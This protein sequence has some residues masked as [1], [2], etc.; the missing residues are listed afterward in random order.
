M[1]DIGFVS[2]RFA[3]KGKKKKKRKRKE[4]E[5]LLL[6]EEKNTVPVAR[7]RRRLRLRPVAR[8]EGVNR[9]ERIAQWKETKNN[10]DPENLEEEVITRVGWR[11]NTRTYL[12]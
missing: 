10:S 3:R 1:E 5:L 2:L 8:H 7:L 6:E 4:A 9:R 11:P 12:Q